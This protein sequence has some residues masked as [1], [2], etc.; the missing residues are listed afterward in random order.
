LRFKPHVGCKVLAAARRDAGFAEVTAISGAK[1]TLR[2]YTDVVNFVEAGA[3]I[4]HVVHPPLPSQTRVF[5]S[6]NGLVRYG[7]V[8]APKQTLGPMRSYL[9]HFPA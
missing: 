4:E 6:E 2:F 9:V 5:H 3:P 7:R 8:V 1:L